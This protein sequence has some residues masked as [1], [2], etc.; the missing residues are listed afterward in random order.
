MEIAGGLDH[1]WK[2]IREYRE[3]N[4][5]KVWSVINKIWNIV[6]P[7]SILNMIQAASVKKTWET[8]E[9]LDNCPSDYISGDGGKV[10]W[11]ALEIIALELLGKEDW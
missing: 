11:V 7:G 4:V 5:H 10:S 1:L 2:G 8:F 6:F 3:I 9:E